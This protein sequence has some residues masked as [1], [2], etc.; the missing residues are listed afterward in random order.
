ML[1]EERQ[2][3]ILEKLSTDKKVTLV[4]LGQLLKVSYDS[5]RRDVIELEDRGLLKKVHG[6][7]IAN[8]YLSMKASRGL[9]IANNEFGVISKKAQKL[10]E[11]HSIILMDGGTTNFYLAEQLPKNL[12][13]TVVTNNP[14]LATALAEH[15]KIE[16]I[17]L[18]GSFYKRYQITLGS[19]TMQDL[20]HIN[21]DLYFMGI[22]SVHPQKGLAIRQYEESL[23]KRKMMS[24]S[25]KT[26]ACVIEEK[27]NRI[28][29]YK[30]CDLNDLDYLVTSLHPT[31]KT[32][33][34]FHQSRVEIL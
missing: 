19:K 23:L 4:E 24:V 22:N 30:V 18:G 7:A 5:V 6:G 10:I 20:E 3:L 17:L 33:A 29:N 26:V 16:V 14:H 27:L 1:K 31:D 34:Q 9:G 11:N 21:A 8:S 12:E 32:L 25:R 28:E 13:I 2:Q 15:P